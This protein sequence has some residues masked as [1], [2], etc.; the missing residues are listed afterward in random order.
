MVQNL[1]LK[2]FQEICKIPHTSGNEKEITQF[3]VKF[4]KSKKV[5]HYVDK[6]GN[7]YVRKHGDI[8]TNYLFQAH[9]DMVGAKLPN[10]KH[11]FNK[12]PIKYYVKGGKYIA[13]KETTLGAD[14]GVGVAMILSLIE[15][16]STKDYGFE[17]LLT[18]EEETTCVGAS[19]LEKGWFKNKY[20]I[21]LDS[22]C[23]QEITIGSASGQ[24]FSIELPV[25]REKNNSKVYLLKIYGGKGGHSGAQIHDIRSNVIVDSFVML[26]QISDSNNDINIIKVDA[27]QVVNAIPSSIEIY[28]SYSEDIK[29]VK[30]EM[31]ELFKHY[32]KAHEEFEKNLEFN[33]SEVDGLDLDPLTHKDSKK[34]INLIV[35]SNN[36]L[37]TYSFQQN[38]TTSSTNL[39][40]IFTGYDKITLKW[41][42]RS[43]YHYYD[44]KSA[45][46]IKAVSELADAN[47][48]AGKQTAGLTPML[49]NPLANFI[50][51]IAEQKFKH[52]M[53]IS[54]IHA[55]LEFGFIWQKY[56]NMV[57]VSIG[58]NMW[59][60]H[61]PN[62][63]VEIS[64]IKFVYDLLIELINSSSQIS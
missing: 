48:I 22:E 10:S 49:S 23:D 47:F 18:V 63:Y 2:H 29:E 62:E 6:I 25:Q 52:K 53:S 13:A 34:L 50:K 4:L 5:E 8:N 15:D 35:T 17:A 24:V 55:G 9:M 38:L 36:G 11:D 7:I 28:F 46:K 39:G 60:V 58:P 21:N 30:K 1:V 59:E 32:L 12:D 41:M 43:S 37:N 3:I 42:N 51:K 64:S 40:M 54:S 20:L 31:Q 19:K 45:N 61:T 57:P 33:I 14:N 26:K 16:K 44:I 56:N 27:G